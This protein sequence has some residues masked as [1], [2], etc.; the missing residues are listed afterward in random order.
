M[1]THGS[2]GAAS[3]PSAATGLKDDFLDALVG[4]WRLSGT[5]VDGP[6][7][8]DLSARWVLGHQFVEMHWID[9][10]RP[11]EYEAQV[12]IGWD[13]ARRE[14][15]AHWCDTFGGGYSAVGRG[16]RVGQR[17]EFRF[18]YPSGPFFNTFTHDPIANSWTFRGENGKPDGSRTL[19]MEEVARRK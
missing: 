15:V 14:Y 9:V 12:L 17:V 18:D 1:T 5:M 13:P 16:A 2:A 8:N 3:R 6:V 4:R 10:K 11:P 19:F 7:E